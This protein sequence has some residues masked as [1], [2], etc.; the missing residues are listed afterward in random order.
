MDSGP[1][2][3]A[4]YRPGTLMVLEP[5]DPRTWGPQEG[6]VLLFGRKRVAV[7]VCVGP[8]DPGVSRKHGALEF[9]DGQWQV[10]T[11]GER[12]V[13]V[14]GT[15]VLRKGDDPVA[16]DE[17]CTALLVEGANPRDL[18]L[19]RVHVVGENASPPPPRDPPP[20]DSGTVPVRCYRLSPAERLV[21]TVFAEP[22]LRRC[23]DSRSHSSA[24][25]PPTMNEAVALLRR[26]QPE[27]NWTP[28]RVGHLLQDLRGRLTRLGEDGLQPE[29]G[30]TG[31]DSAYRRR[32]IEVLVGTSTL[33]AED[34][35]LLGPE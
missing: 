27:A 35:P 19:M 16:L 26:L 6:R 10:R 28:G 9:T 34:L 25:Q 13:R 11:L 32:L 5:G 1:I 23:P 18:H 21:T 8:D 33:T 30:S 12:P 4:C 17:G 2:E 15:Y 14:G 3:P 20:D 7:H 31:Y 24:P 22:A 29:P